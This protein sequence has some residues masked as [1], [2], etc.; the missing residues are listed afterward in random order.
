VRL[1]YCE[2]NPYDERLGETAVPLMRGWPLDMKTKPVAIGNC[3][4]TVETGSKAINN[5]RLLIPPLVV[6]DAQAKIPCCRGGR[7]PN[8]KKTVELD[9]TTI[10]QIDLIKV[11]ATQLVK[12][13]RDVIQ[14]FAVQIEQRS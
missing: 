12:I 8:E 2:I 6:A 5:L 1:G 4:H 3:Y 13:A 14:R 9:P 11:E 10:L 7:L